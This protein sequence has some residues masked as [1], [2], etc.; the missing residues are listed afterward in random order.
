MAEAERID[1][2]AISVWLRSEA[3]ENLRM[4]T[5]VRQRLVA[6]LD[7]SDAKG[8]TAIPDRSWWR[9]AKWYQDGYHQLLTEERE[10]AKLALQT[11]R[12][13]MDPALTDEEYERDMRQLAEES[14]REMSDADL[15]AELVRRGIVG[16]DTEPDE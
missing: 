1:G 13:G 4:L 8:S 2:G 6:R 12:A 11:H 15:Q 5:R 14:V 10:R 7:A 16:P 9:V 3:A